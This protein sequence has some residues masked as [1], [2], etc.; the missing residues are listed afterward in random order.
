M[1]NRNIDTFIDY[2]KAN[3]RPGY[4]KMRKMDRDDWLK[5]IGLRRANPGA[6]VAGAI[7]YLLL[8]CG[9]GIAAG[10]L[11]ARKPGSQLRREVSDKLRTG[12]D[13]AAERV[14]ELR[15]EVQTRRSGTPTTYQG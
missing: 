15:T 5:G 4:R 10:L 8:G 7:G 11:M 6:E 9:I 2:M 3:V 12:A 1:A 14:N 13:R